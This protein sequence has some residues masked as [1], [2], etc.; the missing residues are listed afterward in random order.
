MAQ[1]VKVGGTWRSVDESSNCGSVK[2]GGVW[3]SATNGYVKVGGVWKEYCAPVVTTT[4]TPTTTTTT[5]PV[6]TTP[7]TTTPVTTVPVTT[8]TPTPTIINVTL[9]HCNNSVCCCDRADVQWSSTFQNS[10]RVTDSTGYDSGVIFGATT[11]H[12]IG[13]VCGTTY[14]N[15][16][17]T[18][19]VWSSTNGTGSSAQGSKT[20]TL[21]MDA[22]ASTT[23]TTTSTSVTSTLPVTTATSTSSAPSGPCPPGQEPVYG[24]QCAGLYAELFCGPVGTCNFGFDNGGASC[25]IFCLSI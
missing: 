13:K 22:C 14:T 11:F 1:Y 3:K 6:T 10:Y 19:T 21:T 15:L 17:A 9:T 7:V 12:A 8:T 24:T 23:V 25:F 4:T 18:V 16:T 5:V 2:V 20:E